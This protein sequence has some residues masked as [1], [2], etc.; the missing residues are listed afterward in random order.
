MIAVRVELPSPVWFI[1]PI[2]ESN[3]WEKGLFLLGIF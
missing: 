2:K 1:E 3:A